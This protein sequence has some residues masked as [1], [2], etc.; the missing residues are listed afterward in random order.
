M[1]QVDAEDGPSPPREVYEQLAAA[2]PE[3]RA[4]IILRRIEAHPAGRLVLPASE[5]LSAMLDDV[6]LG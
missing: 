1:S 2:S 5:G 4:E 6:D 3:E